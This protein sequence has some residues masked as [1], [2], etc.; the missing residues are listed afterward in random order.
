MGESTGG[1]ALTEFIELATLH[2]LQKTFAGLTG[3]A[4]SIRDA[5]GAA[6]TPPAGESE[7][8][9]R[10]LAG[11][12]SA[13]ACRCSHAQAVSAA[14]AAGAPC[15]VECHAHLTQYAAPLTV[16]GQQLGALVV[17]DRPRRPLT[18]DQLRELSRLHGLEFE[19][20]RR[21]AWGLQ[22]W[23]DRESNAAVRFSQLLAN[24][25][26]RLCWQEFELRRRVEEL[27]TVYGVS[28]LLAGERE[29]KEVLNVAAQLVADVLKVRA[30]SI[31]LL[32]EETGELKIAA[33]HNLSDEYLNKGPL[34]ASDSPIDQEA[35]QGRLVYLADMPSDPRTIYKDEAR[36]EGIASALV[37]AL[38]YRGKHIGVMRIYSG[39]Q[40]QFSPLEAA[41]LRAVAGQVAAAIIHARMRRAAREAE[42]LERQVKLAGEVQRRMIPADVPRMARLEIGCVYEPSAELGGDF[43]DFIEFTGGHLG[44]AIADVVGKGVP[45]SLMMASVRAALRAHARSIHDIDDIMVETNRQLCRDRQMNAF[46]TAF[47]GVLDTAGMRFTYCN[48]GHEPVRLL[49]AG[50]IALLDAGGLAL[51]IDADEH[52]ERGV[53]E[54][55]PGDVLT[56]VTDGVIE[57]L[58]YEG[59][60]FG[61]GRLHDSI[62]AHAGLAAPHLAQQILWDVRR[63]AGLA[64][65]SDDLTVVVV[66]VG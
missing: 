21:A 58:D 38:S 59:Q 24:A 7:F 28:T 36:R 15:R 47:Y 39:E 26:A 4:I 52:Y 16:N 25:L 10:M 53:Q 23:S 43:Y 60:Q 61:R 40:R 29:L 27:S 48:A 6:L 14:L 45:A 18:D 50:E 31:R 65:Q 41:L 34:H 62:R 33:V 66:R 44:V 8:C 19:P 42:A 2:E 37:A 35:L 64:A 54:L 20:L 51:G 46:V 1:I 63:F 9:Q 22:R 3:V 30:L 57:A 49:R 12:S 5:A 11:G 55:R 17:G 13:E 56:F 32:D